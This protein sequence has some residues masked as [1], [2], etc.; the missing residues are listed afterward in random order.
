MKLEEQASKKV[1][2]EEAYFYLGFYYFTKEKDMGAAKCW[3]TK[4]K[5]LN[6]GTSNTKVGSDMLLT[7]ELKDVGAKDCTLL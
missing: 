4:L 7:K 6:A 5:D 1:E 2:L 3:F